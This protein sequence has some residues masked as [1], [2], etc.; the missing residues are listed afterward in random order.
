MY[1]AETMRSFSVLLCACV[2]LE[3]AGEAMVPSALEEIPAGKAISVAALS[4]FD[5]TSV[6]V[7]I[8]YQDRLEANNADMERVNAHLAAIE[9]APDEDHWALVLINRTAI[10]VA[11]F[12]RSRQLDIMG[13][14]QIGRSA[15]LLQEKMPPGFVP[16][17]CATT[18][19]AAL[20]KFVH[21]DRSYVVLGKMP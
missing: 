20:T 7:L 2:S 4:G 15:H 16:S 11:T 6:C 10:E 12:K 21:Q 1:S 19:G 13:Q 9:Y 3:V 17:T 5:F 18:P 8:P 14:A